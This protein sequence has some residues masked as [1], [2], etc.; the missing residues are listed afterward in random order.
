[1]GMSLL[2]FVV[3]NFV[4][5]TEWGEEL[6]LK[7]RETGMYKEWKERECPHGAQFPSSNKRFYF[8]LAL[9]V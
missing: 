4:G 1:M 2:D 3:I 6:N 7:K 8:I 5:K 9:W